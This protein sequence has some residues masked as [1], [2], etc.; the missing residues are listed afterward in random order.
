MATYLRLP[1]VMLKATADTSGRNA[2]NWSA[3]FSQ[4]LYRINVP[5]F[6][7]SHASITNASAGAFVELLVG[8]D[9]YGGTAINSQQ[10]IIEYDPTNPPIIVP[11]QDISFLFG[12]SPTGT[13]PA[14]TVTAFFRFDLDIP[15]NRR[16]WEV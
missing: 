16:T 5:L 4:S 12:N 14:P 13:V 2:G 10:G 15:A 7:L 3:I 6:E 1:P 9:V 11:G 8:T